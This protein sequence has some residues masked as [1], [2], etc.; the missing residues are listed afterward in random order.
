[1]PITME[2]NMAFAILL[3]GRKTED[4]TCA[5]AA[6]YVGKGLLWQH[7]KLPPEE[8]PVQKLE[9]PEI[10]RSALLAV[11]TRPRCDQIDDGALVN[12]RG[13]ALDPVRSDG[14]LSSIRLWVHQNRVVSTS[15]VEL[16]ATDRV[17]TAM[18]AGRLLD[19]G[20]IVALLAREISHAVDPEVSSLGDE[21]DAC[22]QQLDE[23]DIYTLRRMIA[24]IRAR[25]IDFRRFIAPDRDAL[26]ELAGLQVSWLAEED[27]LH[28]REAADR[29]ARMAEELDA[30]RD[31]AAL[32]HE[33]LT[34][35][36]AEM[37]D[38]RSLMIAVV[39]FVFL[40]LTFVTGLLGMNVQGI[41]FAQEPWAFWGVMAFCAVVGMATVAWF[42]ARHWLRR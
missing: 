39:A 15:Q 17:A 6:V 33:Q 40:P 14:F 13:L 19:P 38:Q 11:E 36:R 1:M 23:A 41:P 27:R 32:V 3:D 30:I 24:K 34:D 9:L 25:A 20:D 35:M 26:I 18:R 4:L 37:I 21:L 7:Y 12:L 22:E 28:V 5:Q 29:F 10:V 42:G 8:V 16:G 2:P 31:R